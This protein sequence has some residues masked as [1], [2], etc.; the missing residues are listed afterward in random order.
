MGDNTHVLKETESAKND[1]QKRL[2]S[3][4]NT[5][6][7]QKAQNTY[8]YQ[9]RVLAACKTWGGP[10]QSVEELNAALL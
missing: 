1:E 2:K 8:A 10:C 5:K 3:L 7:Y 9:N 4:K 6:K